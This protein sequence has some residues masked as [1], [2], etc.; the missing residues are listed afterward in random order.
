[1]YMAWD[2]MKI[3]AMGRCGS[4]YASHVVTGS[5]QVEG[6]LRNTGSPAAALLLN[7]S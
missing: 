6:R 3:K 5:T 4:R 7:E 2:G 1:M